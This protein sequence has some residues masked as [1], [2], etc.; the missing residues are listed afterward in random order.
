MRI[1][2][3]KPRGMRKYGGLNPNQSR[4]LFLGYNTRESRDSQDE[5][6]S[7]SDDD[8]NSTFYSIDK[9]LNQVN[10]INRNMNLK[11]SN[12]GL[13]MVK[14]LKNG[15]EDNLKSLMTYRH[16]QNRVSVLYQKKLRDDIQ[17]DIKR[18]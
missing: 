18:Q 6:S 14:Q 13:K 15:I 5:M 9:I 3:T 12:D 4:S 10:P 17:S 7:S 8:D 16:Q 2:N 1:K 11:L